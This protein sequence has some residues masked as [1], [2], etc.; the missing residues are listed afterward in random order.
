MKEVRNGEEEAPLNDSKRGKRHSYERRITQRKA[1]EVC[2]CLKYLDDLLSSKSN[3]LLSKKCHNIV[4]LL[5]TRTSASC[6][7]HSNLE[8][9]KSAKLVHARWRRVKKILHIETY[10][11]RKMKM[12][13]LS[14]SLLVRRSLCSVDE[15]NARAMT[16]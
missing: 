12:F 1:R 16:Q 4:F 3:L 13:F 9:N 11:R 2:V 5:A 10:T 8:H 15:T 14:F 6:V 7:P